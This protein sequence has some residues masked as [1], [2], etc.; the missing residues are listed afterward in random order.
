[1]ERQWPHTPL[2]RALL[3][4][5]YLREDADDELIE[6]EYPGNLV[7]AQAEADVYNLMLQAVAIEQEYGGTIASARERTVQLQQEHLENARGANAAY[8]QGIKKAYRSVLVN[9]DNA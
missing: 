3:C 8:R 4:I 7:V 9:L 1:M 5:G 6:P 2:A